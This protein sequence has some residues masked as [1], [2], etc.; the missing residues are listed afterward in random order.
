[1]L[2][3]INELPI[4]I[5]TVSPSAAAEIAPD[6]V[7]HV[8]GDIFKLK[9]TF[10]NNIDMCLT[11]GVPLPMVTEPTAAKFPDVFTFPLLAILKTSVPLFCPLRIFPLLVTLKVPAVPLEDV[12]LP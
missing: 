6:Q 3:L 5:A 11:M 7:V 2:A 1:M 4:P 8:A 9:A 12:L 10:W